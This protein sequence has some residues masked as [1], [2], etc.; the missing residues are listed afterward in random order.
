[1]NGHTTGFRPQTRKYYRTRLLQKGDCPEGGWEMTR[2]PCYRLLVDTSRHNITMFF[3]C[4][5]LF[6]SQNQQK[7]F[8][9]TKGNSFVLNFLSTN[10]DA[11]TSA[12]NQQSGHFVIVIIKLCLYRKIQKISPGAYLFQRPFLR[13]LFLE[14]PIFGEAYV[15]RENCV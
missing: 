5:F 15:R 8:L 12:E 3:V 10:M 11:V 14:G 13:G 6:F 2:R 1:M 4:L 7:S 9:Q